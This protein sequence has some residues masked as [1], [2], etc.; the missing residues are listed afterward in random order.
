VTNG[1][2]RDNSNNTT[3]HHGIPQYT[4]GPTTPQFYQP[5]P[6]GGGD[7]NYAVDHPYFY[8]SPD[9]SPSGSG[10][11]YTIETWIYVRLQTGGSGTFYTFT[12]TQTGFDMTAMF[13]FYFGGLGPGH[14]WTDPQDLA[15]I[16]SGFVNNRITGFMP[17]NGWHHFAAVIAGPN[18]WDIYLDGALHTSGIAGDGPNHTL[19]IGGTFDGMLSGFA[20]FGQSLTA[21]QIATHYAA[22]TSNAAYKAAILA[23]SPTGLWMLDVPW[24]GDS[25]GATV[26]SSGTDVS[27]PQGWTVGQIGMGQGALTTDYSTWSIWAF[28]DSPYG[29]LYRTNSN[30]ATPS[31][32][33]NAAPQS[34]MYLYEIVADSNSVTGYRI[35]IDES[36]KLSNWEYFRDLLAAGVTNS[37]QPLLGP[38]LSLSDTTIIFGYSDAFATGSQP[39]QYGF[40]VLTRNGRSLSLSPVQNIFPQTLSGFQVT[41]NMMARYDNTR[42]AYGNDFQQQFQVLQGIEVAGGV[43]VTISDTFTADIYSVMNYDAAHGAL[44]GWN[45]NLTSC[46]AVPWTP[47]LGQT[48]TMITTSSGRFFNF[49]TRFIDGTGNGIGQSQNQS[50]LPI[51]FDGSSWTIGTA[52]NSEFPF[53]GQNF[54]VLTY[55]PASYS[56]NYG[57]YITYAAQNN[58]TTGFHLMWARTA[59]SG[60]NP[61]FVSMGETGFSFASTGYY[62]TYGNGILRA[63]RHSAGLSA[64]ILQVS[65]NQAF[66]TPLITTLIA[67]GTP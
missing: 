27:R 24:T 19:I 55:Y 52:D 38:Q 39:Q 53:A 40:A 37:Y 56:Y 9:L 17:L 1:I 51:S 63:V 2:A 65:K 10:G 64:M 22:S 23:D 31:S 66:G 29:I 5:G 26:V 4:T 32:S 25:L 30:S 21:G 58:R 59:Q 35:D 28:R 49:E 11:G 12:N 47:E 43:G 8:A 42:F 14:G 60:V 15:T 36:S 6:Y 61:S 18:L 67:F 44:V 50:D 13:G 33:N 41:N 48:G 62:G 20:T 7:L 57:D 54:S 16:S 45:P 46:I 3:L 34:D